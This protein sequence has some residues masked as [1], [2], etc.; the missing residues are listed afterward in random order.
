MVPWDLK[1]LWITGRHNR[2]EASGENSGDTFSQFTLAHVHPLSRRMLL[3][4]LTCQLSEKEER[5]TLEVKTRE[6]RKRR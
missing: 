2:E 3:S 6:G 5:K 4:P 1:F